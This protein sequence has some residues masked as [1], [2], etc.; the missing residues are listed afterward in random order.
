MQ[1]IALRVA[2]YQSESSDERAA[3]ER[4]LAEYE[5]RV[6]RIALRLLNH[7]QDAQDA[8]QEVF[9]RLYKNLRHLDPARGVEPWLFRVT[10]NVC[11]DIARARKRSIRLEDLPEL[12]SPQRNAHEILEGAQRLEALR[13]ALGRL[14]EK[15]RAA[16]VLRDIEGF[17]TREV[18]EILGSSEATVRSQICT[19]RLK[20]REFTSRLFR[21]RS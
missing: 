10:V 9:L 4:M 15:E 12:C 17:S 7:Q 19:G 13:R 18:A 1:G 16:I 3:F 5:R 6:L 20:I 21:G 8:A 14:G 2:A 11:R